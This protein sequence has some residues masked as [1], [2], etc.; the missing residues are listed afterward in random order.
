[1]A[2]MDPNEIGDRLFKAIESERIGMLGVVGGPRDHFQPMTSFWEAET[3]SLWFYTY[4]DSDLVRKVGAGQ[5][6][7]FTF[8]DKGREVWACIGGD[9]RRTH[10]AERIQKLWNPVVAAWYPEGKDDPRLT[11]LQ[12]DAKDA[13]I[14]VDQKGPVRFGLDILKSNLTKTTP[15]S[16][17]HAKLR[18]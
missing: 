4:E 18:L 14:W 12:L 11:L 6:A 8:V 10:D 16:G 15:D 1:M 3:R 17:G 7:M 13:E 9:L 5:P 2:E